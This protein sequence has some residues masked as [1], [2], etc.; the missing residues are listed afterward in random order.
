MD[1]AEKS[2]IVEKSDKVRTSK[3]PLRAA[4]RSAGRARLDEPGAAVLS[5]DRRGQLRRAQQKYRQKKESLLQSTRARVTELESQIDKVAEALDAVQ[6]I[7]HKSELSTTHSTL[8]T[9]M[10][11]IENLLAHRSQRS[12]SLKI[13]QSSINHA[14]DGSDA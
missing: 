1:A 14:N 13:S 9:H 12:R 10:N 5:A 3:H 4:R 11:K 8:V 7:I 6:D 2:D